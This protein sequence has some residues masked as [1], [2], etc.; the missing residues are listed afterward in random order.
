MLMLL[1]KFS[2]TSSTEALTFS[3]V[4]KKNKRGIRALKVT[5]KD[6]VTAYELLRCKK[7]LLNEQSICVS[8]DLTSFQRTQLN[9]IKVELLERKN[10][11]EQ[12]IMLKYVNDIP[13]IVV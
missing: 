11:Y 3:R 7:G 8:A 5:L 1:N 13:E 2:L 4:G 6:S 10:N 12:Y 9:K